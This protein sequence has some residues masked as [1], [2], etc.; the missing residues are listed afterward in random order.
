[1]SRIV[2]PF[3][4]SK[5]NGADP[6]GMTSALVI[7]ALLLDFEH[8]EGAPGDPIRRRSFVDSASVPE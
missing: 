8:P 6:I 1:M 7:R 3:A 4:S 2:M 5:I